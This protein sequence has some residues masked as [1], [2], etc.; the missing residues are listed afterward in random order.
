MFVKHLLPAFVALGSVAAQSQTCTVSTTTI[1]SQ[2]EATK[3]AGCGTVDGTIVISNTAG[4]NIDISG[5]KKI[6]GDLKIENNGAIVT[7]ASSSLSS[8]SG[9]FLVNNVTQ[10][11]S[12]DFEQLTSV[13]KLEL[14]SVTNLNTLKFGPLTEAKEIDISDTFLTSLDSIQ[15]S[16]VTNF[17]INN[18]R[19]LT[20][21][22][23][24]LKTLDDVLIV[25]ANGLDFEIDLPKLV[26]IANMTIANVSTFS[27]PA[28]QVVNGSARF[29]SNKFSTFSAPNLTKTESGDISFVGNA[30]LTNISIPKLTSIGGGLLIANNTA[31]HKIN[32]FSKLERVGGAVKLRGNFTDVEFPALDDVQGA[33]DVSSTGDITSSCDKLQAS[34]PRNQ[35][36]D[37]KFQ[38]TFSCTSNNERANEDTGTNTSSTGSTGGSGDNGENSASSAAFNAALFGLVAVAALASA[39]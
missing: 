25:S 5:P 17:N 18:N 33:F 38:G 7:L 32:F 2:A 10:L 8:I 30:A 26:W 13:Q 36:G 19:R 27:V 3:L 4:G 15:A 21:V 20:K 28:L 37:G 31:L 22:T 9:T 34:A 6:T 35:G 12:I 11:N 39:L 24:S 29:D 16:S 1:Q 23:S 14:Q